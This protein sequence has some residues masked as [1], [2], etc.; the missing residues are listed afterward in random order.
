IFT[1]DVLRVTI[2]KWF[3]DILKEG[4]SSKKLFGTYLGNVK[5]IV[6]KIEEG[7]N[8]FNMNNLGESLRDLFVEPMKLL[9][10]TVQTAITEGIG[11]LI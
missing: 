8:N 9:G 5:A 4:E 2:R 3:E 7:L 1:F 11:R 10:Q 6:T